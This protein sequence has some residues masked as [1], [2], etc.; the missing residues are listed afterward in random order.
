ML[1]GMFLPGV[2]GTAGTVAFEGEKRK[3]WSV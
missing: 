1:C 3:G 2:K